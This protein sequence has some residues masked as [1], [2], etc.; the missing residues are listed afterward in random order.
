MKRILIV[1]F[2]IVIAAFCSFDSSMQNPNSI[3][4]KQA[5]ESGIWLDYVD[6]YVGSNEFYDETLS[7][8]ICFNYTLY[9]T[10]R[11]VERE[12]FLSP[13][14][15]TFLLAYQYYYNPQE[16]PAN[17]TAGFSLNPPSNMQLPFDV[18]EG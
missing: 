5:G 4:S 13:D 8:S 17:G 16:R 3:T 2:L 9:G 7:I 6:T 12:L 15:V 14:N 10:E 1:G 18:Y 11:M